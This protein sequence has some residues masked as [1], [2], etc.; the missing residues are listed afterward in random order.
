MPNRTPMDH[1]LRYL[2]LVR[3][4][5]IGGQYLALVV[6]DRLFGTPLPWGAINTVLVVMAL[7]TAASWMRGRGGSAAPSG[8]VYLVQ[9]LADVAALSA[10]VYFTGGAFNPFISLFLLP[11]VFAA[12]ALPRPATAAV[13]LIAVACYTAL[14]LVPAPQPHAQ[15]AAAGSFSLHVWGM[16]YGFILSAVCVALFVAGLAR[17]LRRRDHELATLRE[18]ALAAE[19]FLALGT[20]AA[21]TAHELG[22]PLST[23]AILAGEIERGA[24]EAEI[25]AQA[26][27]LRAQLGRCK[28][29]LNRMSTTAGS[30]RASDGEA[31][32]VDAFVERVV[33][34][35]R[36]R[37]P[38]VAIGFVHGGSAPV[39]A[40]VADRVLTQ[41]IVNVLDNAAQA[42]GSRVDI[43]GQWSA[44]E[45]VLTV[46]DDGPG[47]DATL[48]ARLGR[49]AVTTKQDGMGIGVLLARTI[50]E[51]LGGALVLEPGAARGTLARIVIPITPLSPT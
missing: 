7:F 9:L 6:M 44:E 51:R 13:A 11:I 16:W 32:A 47:I 34:E 41:A 12:A 33:G 50:I 20:L 21:G 31:V 29:I 22:T 5:V 36:H 43:D 2:L 15:H 14:M 48:G 37:H 3:L 46:A 49:E 17:H 19:R 38:E 10:L 26:A 28:E 4:V 25:R 42:A 30:L 18:E 35:W 1:I 39:P 27:T 23:M 24:G 45:L 40:I 8:R